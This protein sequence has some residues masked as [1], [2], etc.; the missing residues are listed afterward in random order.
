MS[1]VQQAGLTALLA[2]CIAAST[3]CAPQE[4]YNKK[5][6]I[7]RAERQGQ[8]LADGTEKVLE[9]RHF[10]ID[11][12][13]SGRGLVYRTGPLRYDTDFYNEFLASPEVMIADKVRHWMAESKLF[14]RVVE[15]G[16]YTEPTHVLEANVIALYGD[17][18]DRAAPEA[19]L[20]MRIFVLDMTSDDAPEVV[21]GETYEVSHRI[22]GGDPDGV[23][24]AMDAC[25]VRILQSLESDLA[26]AL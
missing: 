20:K 7:L 8:P 1:R 5:H 19:V 24:A 13:F 3:G 2:F 10:T 12:A 16:S 26:K 14:K 25:L 11:S 15:G 18:R 21:F 17:F 9:V 4:P 6:Y 22:E 23:V